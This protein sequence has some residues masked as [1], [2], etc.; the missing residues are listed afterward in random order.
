MIAKEHDC[1]KY[2]KINCTCNED[3]CKHGENSITELLRIEIKQL[4]DRIKELS[5]TIIE[6]DQRHDS[7][8]D[9][10]KELESSPEYIKGHADGYIDGYA[11]AKNEL[12]GR[13]KAI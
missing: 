6:C 2:A 13:D 1:T 7:D 5:A 4:Q 3:E 8:Q 12:Q 9:R 11:Q 10:I